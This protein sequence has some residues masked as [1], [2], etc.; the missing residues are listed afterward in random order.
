MATT[1]VKSRHYPA[2]SMFRKLLNKPKVVAFHDEIMNHRYCFANRG[3]AT[4]RRWISVPPPDDRELQDNA[5]CQALQLF[6]R[7][8][9]RTVRPRERNCRVLL[10]EVNDQSKPHARAVV[11]RAGESGRAFCCQLY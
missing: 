11:I 4:S 6:A 5:G 8:P 3:H 10:P 1:D 2:M 7:S 9:G